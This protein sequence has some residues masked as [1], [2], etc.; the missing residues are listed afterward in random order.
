M[1]IVRSAGIKLKG[2]LGGDTHNAEMAWKEVR[3]V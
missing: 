1:S 3:G 2:L